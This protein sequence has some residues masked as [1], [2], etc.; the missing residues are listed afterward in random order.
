MRASSAWNGAAMVS[1]L[2]HGS[3]RGVRHAPVRP[4]AIRVADD[5]VVH[6]KKRYFDL[7]AAAG[8]S[9]LS[10]KPETD[11]FYI[12]VSPAPA[13][14]RWLTV[15][16]FHVPRSLRIAIHPRA[17]CRIGT[18]IRRSAGRQS[19]RRR[20][21]DLVGFW[22]ALLALL[23]IRTKWRPLNGGELELISKL[24][25]EVKLRLILVDMLGQARS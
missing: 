19:Q 17:R 22:S 23:H 25:D 6:C 11:V 20:E 10:R 9:L 3:I 12:S 5:R 15:S 24:A 21:F 2:R 8:E 13:A 1:V 16:G 14:S 18:R 4:W 7:D